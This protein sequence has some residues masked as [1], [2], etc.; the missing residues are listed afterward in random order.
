[1]SP[2]TSFSTHHCCRTFGDARNSPPD[3]TRTQAQGRLFNTAGSSGI[4]LSPP[5]TS[6]EVAVWHL[7]HVARIISS[8]RLVG[9]SCLMDT[10]QYRAEAATPYIPSCLLAPVMFQPANAPPQTQHLKCCTGTSP[11]L[12]YGLNLCD[13]LTACEGGS[14]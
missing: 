5:G 3:G 13:C 2:G 14:S 11:G 12:T 7:R 10:S 9:H 6:Q 4:P 1:M 8:Q